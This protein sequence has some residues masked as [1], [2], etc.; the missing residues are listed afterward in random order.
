MR[1]DEFRRLLEDLAGPI[2]ATDARDLTA[3]RKRARHERT[4]RLLAGVTMVVLVL[5]VAV[6]TTIYARSG[7]RRAV[8]ATHPGPQ[9]N[10]DPCSLL[11]ASEV[12]AAVGGQ[13]QRGERVA[14]MGEV[15]ARRICSFTV[16]TSLR[17]VIVYLRRGGPPISDGERLAAASPSG[18]SVDSNGA[19]AVRATTYISVAAQFPDHTFAGVAQ[20]LL[21]IAMRRAGGS[22]VPRRPLRLPKVAH[23]GRC[24]VTTVV[25]QPTPG[26]GPMLGTGPA[27]PVGRADGVLSYVAP[28]RPGDPNYALNGFAGSKWGGQKVLWAV[29]PEVTTE[30]LVRGRQLDGSGGVRFGPAIDPDPELLLPAPSPSD[31]RVAGGWRDFPGYTRLQHP[32]CYA[33]QV[34]TPS[35]SNVIVFH[36]R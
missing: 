24:P 21:A 28:P 5:G 25:S 29:A 1:T 3:V 36:A 9:M 6:G 20:D 30:V 2:P 11:T 10:T 23:G 35:T 16:S 22:S 13:A 27:R 14:A 19:T 12:A 34:D 31:S 18:T 32:G 15:D 26:L 4:L 8:L 7:S 17:T 33:Y